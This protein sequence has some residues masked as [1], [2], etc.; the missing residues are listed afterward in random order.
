MASRTLC[1]AALIV[2]TLIAG[3]EGASPTPTPVPPTATTAALP[4]LSGSGG[5]RIAFSSR[6]DGN[7]EIYVMNADGTDQRRLTKTRNDEEGGAAW[8]PD[9]TQIAFSSS[10]E[11][12]GR[13]RVMDADGSNVR[14]L[15]TKAGTGPRWSPDGTRIAFT[16]EG[17]RGADIYVMDADGT[18]QK[19]LTQTDVPGTD[20]LAFGPD[21]SPD[22]TQIVC[23]V[24]FNPDHQLFGEKT[25][26]VL[27]VQDALQGEGASIAHLRPLPPA[28][29]PFNDHPAWS[30]KGSEIAFS[31]VVDGQRDLYV[32]NADGTNLR[33]LTQTKDFDEFS[34]AWSPDGTQIVFQA[35]PD[36]N[37]D[38]YRM[39]A[40]GTGR[41]R[42]TTDTASD[43][44]PNWVP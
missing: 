4:P 39:N 30:P 31:A 40:D 1:A 8:S 5:G 29:R 9:G 35:N 36:G 12:Y 11:S 14:R 41:Q 44:D 6:R 43:V 34:P 20:T 28:G 13:I 27:N 24:E 26:H 21:W 17:P 32:V 23:V 38:I 10:R 2:L 15:T 18:H 37:W 42:L 33:P 22:G 19:R 7:Y 16:R 3:C 25:I